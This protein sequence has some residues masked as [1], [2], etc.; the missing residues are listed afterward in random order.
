MLCLHRN[1]KIDSIEKFGIL[2]EILPGKTGLVHTSELDVD[3]TVSPDAFSPE[4]RLA[5]MLLAV[6]FCH[7]CQ[8]APGS[9][10]C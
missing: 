5:V 7:A 9:Y 1:C 10:H 8:L 4:D 3:R 2:V 6:S